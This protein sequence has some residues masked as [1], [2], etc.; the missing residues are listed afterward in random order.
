M[1]K[2]NWVCLLLII[3]CMIVFLH[4]KTTAQLRADTTPPEITISV[5]NPEFSVQDSKAA[6]LEHV[7]AADARDGDVT[8]SLVVESVKLVDSDGTIEIIYAAFDAAGNVAKQAQTARLTDYRQPEFLLNA[9]LAFPLNSGYDILDIV[10]ARDAVDGDISHRIRATSL[11]KTSVTTAGIHEVEFRVSNSLGDTV[12]LV[13][14]VEVFPS[15]LY[16]AA[17]T[18]TDYL[19]Y[20]PQDASFDARDYLSTFTYGSETISLSNGI[21]ENYSLKLAGTVRTAVP[22]VYSVTYTLTSG[23]RTGYSRLIVVV[24]G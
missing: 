20:L 10:Q 1:K 4:Y 7:S 15:N 12:K 18:L 13:L 8:D 19:I 11:D 21:P 22:G 16:N 24:E 6:L 9:P 2:R 14:P 5:T 17:L 23:T 3:L